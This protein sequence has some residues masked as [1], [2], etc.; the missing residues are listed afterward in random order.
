MLERMLAAPGE[1]AGSGGRKLSDYAD[2]YLIRPLTGT[3]PEGR[4]RAQPGPSSQ[5]PRPSRAPLLLQ[6]RSE[7]S[8]KASI[9]T[10]HTGTSVSKLSAALRPSCAC[11][12][13]ARAAASS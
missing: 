12:G 5:Q 6:P 1:P 7:T 3:A 9:V 13:E 11:M 8:T 4:A 10:S 2:N